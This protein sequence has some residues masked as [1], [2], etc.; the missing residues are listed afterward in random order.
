MTSP[1]APPPPLH[2]SILDPHGVAAG[3]TSRSAGLLLHL[4]ANPTKVNF[5][6]STVRDVR[7]LEH[8]LGES[9]G[10]QRVGSLRVSPDLE[11]FHALQAQATLLSDVLARD[12][13]CGNDARD[14]EDR[15]A[16]L[17]WISRREAEKLVPWLSLGAADD[18]MRL[19]DEVP[20]SWLLHV[21]A[22]AVMDPAVLASGYLRGARSLEQS[23]GAQ[24]E[25]EVLRRQVVG[26]WSAANRTN[27]SSAGTGHRSVRPRA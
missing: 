20:Q 2:I 7:E 18:D 23:S 6:I 3:S 19:R 5:S 9:L 1:P 21:G 12:F 16:P 13:G 17:R 4:S 11:H 27:A 24:L 25:L 14:H 22:D 10:M 26:L 8:T 15:A